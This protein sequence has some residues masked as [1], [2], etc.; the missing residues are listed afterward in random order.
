[1]DSAL[2]Q[3]RLDLFE[4]LAL[5]A[6]DLMTSFDTKHGCYADVGARREGLGTPTEQRSGCSDQVAC[7]HAGSTP[8]APNVIEPLSIRL[9]RFAIGSDPMRASY[10]LSLDSTR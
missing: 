5:T 1:M 2:A 3:R 4:S 9:D 7:D 6:R 8:N 10:A